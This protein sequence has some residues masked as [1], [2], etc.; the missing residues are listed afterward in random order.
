MIILPVVGGRGQPS[1]LFEVSRRAQTEFGVTMVWSGAAPGYIWHK[2]IW[3]PIAHIQGVDRNLP[4]FMPSGVGRAWPSGVI[5]GIPDTN[6]YAKDLFGTDGAGYGTIALIMMPQDGINR[7]SAGFGYAVNG[8]SDS[9][10]AHVPWDDGVCYFDFGGYTSGRISAAWPKTARKEDRIVFLAGPTERAIFRNS[11]L[12][13]SNAVSGNILLNNATFKLFGNASN[14]TDSTVQSLFVTA[15]KTWTAK[16]AAEWT[17]NPWGVLVDTAKR[18]FPVSVEASGSTTSISPIALSQSHTLSGPTVTT[19]TATTLSTINVEHTHSFNN[20]ALITGYLL[21]SSTVAHTQ[22]LSTTT[23]SSGLLL[24]PAT[25]VHT[26]TLTEPILTLALNLS[27]AALAHLQTLSGGD[28]DA[29]VALIAASLAQTHALSAVSISAATQLLVNAIEH[30]HT[31]VSGSLETQSTLVSNSIT[32]QLVLEAASTNYNIPLIVGNLTHL[33]TIT[34]TGVN[35]LVASNLYQATAANKPT[36]STVPGAEAATE[37]FNSFLFDAT[38]SL[39]CE[40]NTSGTPV[41]YAWLDD[42]TEQTTYTSATGGILTF[43]VPAGRKLLLA[44]AHPS[45]IGTECLDKFRAL[46]N[47][48]RGV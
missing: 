26:Q 18:I 47:L 16:Q 12:V 14:F 23:L 3:R 13:A 33:S 36:L 1:S 34:Q 43:N 2:G 42:G 7:L 32:H 48:I 39:S 6:L 37:G 35:S 44:V 11:V 19:S 8:A 27:P 4:D 31:F 15:N 22:A 9:I 20:A 5:A 45:F 38:D 40:F 10:Q 28:V 24:T 41:F 25:N 29:G 30:T 21:T 17:A 46:A